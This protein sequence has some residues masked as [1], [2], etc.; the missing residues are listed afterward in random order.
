MGRVF[1]HPVFVVGASALFLCR[2][3]IVA[4][5][6]AIIGMPTPILLLGGTGAAIAAAVRWL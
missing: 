1:F 6:S 2:L 5:P 4:L 3:G